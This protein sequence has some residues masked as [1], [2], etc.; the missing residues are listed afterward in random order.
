[1]NIC[2]I[3]SHVLRRVRFPGSEGAPLMPV[4]SWRSRPKPEISGLSCMLLPFFP[5]KPQ[6]TRSAVPSALMFAAAVLLRPLPKDTEFAG[7]SCTGLGPPP[8]MAA[9]EEC[10]DRACFC[11]AEVMAM[12]SAM[13]RETGS[14][15]TET[16]RLRYC[17]RGEWCCA[18]RGSGVVGLEGI[19][20]TG[21]SISMGTGASWLILA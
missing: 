19:G 11:I 16:G 2:T 20:D 12:H 10:G 3:V 8:K 13:T 21:G 6:R 7:P 14:T 5:L 17:I 4:S 1:M 15:A 9:T 18:R